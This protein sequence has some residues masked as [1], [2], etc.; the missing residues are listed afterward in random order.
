MLIESVPESYE[1]VCQTIFSYLSLLSRSGPQPASFLEI[2]ALA[3]LSFAFAEKSSAPARTAT[4]LARR[5]SKPWPREWLLSTPYLSR[6]YDPDAV[7]RTLKMLRVERC[8][9]KV[10]SRTLP[11]GVDGTFNKVE[12]IYGTEFRVEKISDRFLSDVS[13]LFPSS[14]RSSA[15]S[16]TPASDGER[17]DAGRPSSP[18]AEPFRT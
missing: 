3:S 15:V 18:K 12:P 1:A 5:L 17:N 6:E 7:E 13:F 16:D 2:Q 14:Q 4:A 11:K 8:R 10:A 9:I